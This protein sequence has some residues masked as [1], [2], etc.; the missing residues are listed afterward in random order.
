MKEALILA[1]SNPDSA[2]TVLSKIPGPDQLLSED[3]ADYGNLIGL[4]HFKQGKAMAEDSLVLYSL[5]YYKEY[6]K[7]D[8]L[9]LAYFLAANYYRWRD[10]IP[11]YKETIREGLTCAKEQKDSLVVFCMYRSYYGVEAERH[12]YGE[13]LGYLQ[14]GMKYN[15]FSKASTWYNMGI[16]Y[17]RMNRPDSANYYMK[18]SVEY[19]KNEENEASVR[20][21]RRNYA[22][23]LRLEGKFREALKLL[24]ENVTEYGDTAHLS[25]S[26]NYINLGQL[27]SAQLYIG[28]FEKMASKCSLT[29]R[30]MLMS[31]QQLMNYARSNRFELVELAQYNDSVFFSNWREQKLLEEKIYRKNQLEQK[32]LLLIVERQ[33]MQIYFVWSVLFFLVTGLG[34]VLYLQRKRKLL[35]ETEEKREILEQLLKE[36][37]D[38]NEERNNFYKKILLQQLG[39]IRL[40]ANTPTSQNQLLL[41]QVSLIDNKEMS[42]EQI[43]VW[44]DFYQVVDSIY[45][46]FYTQVT[47]K[48]GTVLADKEIQLCCLLCA[49]FSTK[50]I[51]VLTGQKFQTIYQRKT[52]IRQKLRMG[53]KEDIIGYIQS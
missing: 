44:N 14:E 6:A 50:E 22:D 37:C 18:K 33:R 12:N 16:L 42:P 11:V 2:F 7:A 38:T 30:N 20:F 49:G 47:E 5:D 28:E 24:F 3:K 9:P 25:I 4:I 13:A 52:T 15:P 8:K 41:K 34:I 53:E 43:L 21:T 40:V 35:A 48:Y 39:F 1:D 36:T 46:G 51:S 45:E 19:F 10:N 26:L 32:N 23:Q 17:S 31:I 29:S 27:D